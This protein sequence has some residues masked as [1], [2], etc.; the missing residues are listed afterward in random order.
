V[1]AEQ[2]IRDLKITLPAPWE[3]P[4]GLKI[5]AVLIRIHNDRVLISGHVPLDENGHVIGPFGKVGRDVSLAEAQEAAQRAT[6]AI[7]ASLKKT[8]GDLDRIK[9]WLRLYGMVNSAP[10]FNQYPIVLNAASELIHR[11]FGPSIG[12][13]A[14][15]AIGVA[16]LPWDAPVEIEAEVAIHAL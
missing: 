7:L 16:G 12:E 9:G 2:R 13:H 10:E 5:P 1:S 3:L 6:L 14:R 15:V 4:K 8:L 11:I